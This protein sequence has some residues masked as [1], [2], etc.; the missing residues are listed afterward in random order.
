MREHGWL[1]SATLTFHPGS[2]A[3]EEEA[4]KHCMSKPASSH[5]CVR[6]ELSEK[7]C[8]LIKGI[9][10]DVSYTLIDTDPDMVHIAVEKY[11]HIS[12]YSDTQTQ[13]SML[14]LRSLYIPSPSFSD[15]DHICTFKGV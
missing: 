8:D 13:T 12:G 11:L 10:H 4:D 15:V 2:G 14:L 6:N 7:H 3:E 1:N 9:W 5:Y